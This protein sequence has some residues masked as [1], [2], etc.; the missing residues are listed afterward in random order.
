MQREIG[1]QGHL[2]LAVHRPNKRVPAIVKVDYPGS[3]IEVGQILSEIVAE[4]S[5]QR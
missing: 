4:L 3:L 1:P 5:P 2:G